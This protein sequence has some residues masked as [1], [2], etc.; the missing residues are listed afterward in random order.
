MTDSSQPV[1]RLAD[2][3][4]VDEVWDV[5]ASCRIALRE[6]GVMQWDTTYPSVDT[7]EDDI[8]NKTLFVLTADEDCVGV[9]TLDANADA[10]YASLKWKF[11]EPA[12]IVHRLCI[13][14]RLQGRGFGHRLMQFAEDRV[15]AGDYRSIRLDAYSQN[16][17][18]VKF[19]QQRGYRQVGQI[20]FPRRPL[21]FYLFEWAALE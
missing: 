3:T 5:I 15:S 9:V 21:P 7:V 16:A 6:R 2:P 17:S 1:I 4:D 8:A 20:F 10:A 12:L 11:E 19:Y 18:A 14:P 13:R